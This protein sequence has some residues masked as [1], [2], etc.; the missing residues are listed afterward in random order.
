MY[1]ILLMANSRPKEVKYHNQDKMAKLLF[2]V[3]VYFQS[4]MRI[5]EMF[6]II[7]VLVSKSMY[8]LQNF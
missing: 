3:P 4:T 6:L 5:F 2:K 1:M 8:F 7:F